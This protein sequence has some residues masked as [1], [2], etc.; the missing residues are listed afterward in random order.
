MA[1]STLK[2]Q[3]YAALE[4]QEG[5]TGEDGM[6]MNVV[7]ARL[8]LMQ[9]VFLAVQTSSHLKTDILVK[10]LQ[11]FHALFNN[12]FTETLKVFMWVELTHSTCLG[13]LQYLSYLLGFT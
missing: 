11:I 3:V 5:E 12:H 9:A 13:S 7:E 10:G 1:L 2:Q 8:N 4:L 6:G